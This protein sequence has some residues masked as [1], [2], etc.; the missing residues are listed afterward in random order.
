MPEMALAADAEFSDEADAP[1]EPC[2]LGVVGGEARP[3]E[4]ESWLR[5]R[6]LTFPNSYTLYPNYP[7]ITDNVRR[8]A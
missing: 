6:L 8:S 2:L 4:N 5:A 1:E 3:S 7:V